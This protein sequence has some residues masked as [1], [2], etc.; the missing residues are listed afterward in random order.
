[1]HEIKKYHTAPGT[2][3]HF[4]FD[5]SQVRIDKK[6]LSPSMACGEPVEPYV[7]GFKHV[8]SLWRLPPCYCHSLRCV[9][10]NSVLKRT[11]VEVSRGQAGGVSCR[12]TGVFE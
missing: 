1:M 6:I 9:Q 8:A 2:A 11:K 3:T 10:E 12:M 5:E 4:S 7:K